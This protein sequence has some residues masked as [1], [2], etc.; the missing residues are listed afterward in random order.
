[1]GFDDGTRVCTV[2]HN[3][4]YQKEEGEGLSKNFI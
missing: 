2:V 3:H 1:M 4:I